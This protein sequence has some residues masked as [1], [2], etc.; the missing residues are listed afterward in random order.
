MATPDQ[1]GFE[2]ARLSS[3]LAQTHVKA[4]TGVVPQVVNGLTIGED[5]RILR[6]EPVS[7]GI[8]G[9]AVY[10]AL[11]GPTIT[12][13]AD[14]VIDHETMVSD[15]DGLVTT[16]ASWNYETPVAGIY[17][18]F[19][20]L[21]WSAVNWSAG[22]DTKSK[23]FINGFEVD[24]L[25]WQTHGQGAASVRTLKGTVF[26]E[27]SA[28]QLIDIEAYQDSGSGQDVFYSSVAIWCILPY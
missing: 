9:L 8:V 22:V 2:I 4:P 23:V 5:G 11:Y 14:T 19:N 1:L 16:G 18:I 25:D 15:E 12:S 7:S 26:L 10:N 27:I 13:N 28:G 21:I 20:T 24:T 6:A 3:D 17:I